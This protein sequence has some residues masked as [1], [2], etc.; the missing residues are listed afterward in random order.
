MKIITINSLKG[1]TAKTTVSILLAN[2]LASAKYRVLV[3]DMDI[4]NSLSFYYIDSP[5]LIDEK[6]IAFALQKGNLKDNIITSN[7][8]GID[9][10]PSSFNLVDLRAINEKRLKQITESS[11]LEYDFCI[12]D[13]APTY[14]NLVLNSLHASDL[15]ITPF[16][17]SQFDYKSLLFY[18][19]KLQYE[20]DGKIGNWKILPTFYQRPR[21]ANE[22][23][24]LNQYEDLFNSTFNNI[25]PIAIPQ[26][27]LIQKA[28]DT[29]EHINDSRKKERIFTAI[30][31]LA[32][33]I[34]GESI[35]TRSF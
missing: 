3:I 11:H 15:I 28:I 26:S 29:R 31:N 4:Q 14:D 34:A 6:N 25:L 2:C 13:T 12:I 24:L 1:G 5:D 30:K 27:I 23:N 17:F 19:E 16:R 18:Q 9:I 10:I 7:Y 33:F 32:E 22:E 8:P 20:T 35:E 21:T